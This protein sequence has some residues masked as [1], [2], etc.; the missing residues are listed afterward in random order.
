MEKVNP[1]MLGR[2]YKLWFFE[3]L[4]QKHMTDC[5]VGRENTGRGKWAKL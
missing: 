1:R 5:Q 2:V 4:I 3:N